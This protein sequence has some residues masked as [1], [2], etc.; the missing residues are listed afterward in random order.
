MNATKS[1]RRNVFHFV[2]IKPSHYDDDG[3]VIQWLRSAVPSNSLAVLYG[4]AKDCGE[5]DALGPEVTLKIS[6]YD[7]TNTRIKVRKLAARIRR[8]GGR[9][10]VGLV[11]VQSNQFPRAMD[12][13]RQF[14]AEDI[15]V[16]IGGFHVSGCVAMLPELTPEIKEALDCGV[17]L[18]IGEAE[19]GRLE[20]L[21]QDAYGGTLRPMYEAPDELP[22]LEGAPGPILP[23]RK[24]WRTASGY[25][26]F[27][28][29]RGCPFQCSFCTII[30]VQG[31]K[32]RYRT[33]DD[34]EKII[35]ANLAQRIRHFFV[36]DD[37]FA[38]NK[39]WENIFDRLIELREVEGLDIKLVLQ[40]DTMCHKIPNFIE[41]A[42][43]AG[44][45]RVFIGLES[46]NPETLAHAKKRQNRITE[47]RR[48][49]QAWRDV[50]TLTYAGYIV[51][52]PTD[53][54]ETII[55]DIEIIKR[56][57]PLDLLEFFCLT[58]LPGSEDHKNLYL[59]GTWMEP[60]LNQYDSSH[61]TI[62]HPHMSREEWQELFRLAWKTYYSPEH[63]ETVLR[64]ARRS[65][66]ERPTVLRYMMLWFYGSALLEGVHPLEGGLLRLKFRRDRRPGLPI[67]P[68]FAF[69]RKSLADFFRKHAA[70]AKVWWCHRQIARRI[71]ADPARQS[72]TDLS[73]TP[74]S[75]SEFEELDMFTATDAAKAAVIRARPVRRAAR[76]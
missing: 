10:L 7:E 55:R 33:A 28:G 46:I 18:F 29:G 76:A 13:A 36:T 27:D 61:A 65:G 34:V 3:Y 62:E 75:S 39:N 9:G 32:S 74:V 45:T 1:N 54:P 63:V 68:A 30:N 48:M 44:V 59:R 71:A 50:G 57:L 42:A 21:L 73:L 20:R 70:A 5:N 16:C 17:S 31:R 25:T 11:G 41:K 23:A 40:V 72:Y 37:N 58:P 2:L 35:R 66:I 69:Y 4:L 56:E 51:G 47:Y 6:A 19:E 60:D 12:L 22:S 64:R 49:V 52:F 24:I 14:L 26:S 38:R 53:T 15:P 8:G 67:E 43:R